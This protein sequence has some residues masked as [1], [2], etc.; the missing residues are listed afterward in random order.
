[1]KASV[2][3]NVIIHLYRSGCK[4]ILFS[5]FDEILVHSF[6]YNIELRNHGQD[7]LKDFE[8]DIQ[9]GFICI[10]DS[11]YLSERGIKDIFDTKFYENKILYQPQDLG[12]VY[13]ISLAETLDIESVVTDDIKQYGP[14]YTL[15][16]TIDT[17]VIPFAFHEVLLLNYLKGS[18]SADEY[19]QLFEKI[20]IRCNLKWNI[21]SKTTRSIKR[22]LSTDG[23]QREVFW[24]EQYCTSYHTDFRKK[25]FELCRI[26]Q[27]S[28]EKP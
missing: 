22:F 23:F 9:A 19:I 12:E 1:M 18:I 17:N 25:C 20:N 21:S 6:I 11:R 28:Q 8:R 27:K 26:I 24:M 4:E 5:A 13:A 16:R 3:T 10:V 2:D 14:H 7:I 15:T